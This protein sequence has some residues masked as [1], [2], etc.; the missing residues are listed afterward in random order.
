MKI[1]KF[2]IIL[3]IVVGFSQCGSSKFETNP[4]FVIT[5][6][7]YNNW[8]VKESDNKGMVVNINYTSSY[9]VKFDSIFF[10]KKA[11]KLTIN[12]LNNKKTLT[13]NFTFTKKPDVILSKNTI[14][15]KSNTIPII[16]KFPFELKRNE[17]IIS[18]KVKDKINYFKINT[19]KKG[20]TIFYPIIQ[21]K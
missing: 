19:I 6:A 10:S 17:A 4:P 12:R 3:G 20:K 16:N 1:F 9:N 21:K 11:E 2:F 5:D 8:F 15:E 13:A 7:V 14:E 18:Y